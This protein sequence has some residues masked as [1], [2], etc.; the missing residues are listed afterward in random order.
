MMA[1]NGV[2]RRLW[3]VAVVL[4][5]VAS[6]LAVGAAPVSGVAGE[7][8]NEPVYS[9]C[10]GPALES[11]G[12]VDVVG[13]FAEDA[14]NCLA[15]FEVTRGRTETTYDPGAPVLRWQMALFLARAAGPAGIA[16][17]ANPEVG[18]TDTVGLFEEGRTAIAQMAQ[19]RVMRGR[20]STSFRP[21]EPVSRAE[22]AEMLD[23]FLVEAEKASGLGLGAL[24]GGGVSLSDVSADD[25][26]FSDIGSVTRGQYAAVR[27]MFEAGVARGAADG[28]FNPG[29]LVTRAQMAVFITRM[30]AH[31]AARPAGLTIQA[32]ESEAV[33]GDSVE[34]AVS[35]RDND[36][37]P[38]P[39]ALVDVFSAVDPG[40]AFGEDGR[41]D[42]DVVSVVGGGGV[43][44]ISLA[45]LSTD[46]SGDLELSADGLAGSTTVW[47]W[48]GDE[49]DRYD[50]GETEA[51]S[52]RI[53]VVKPGV[54]LRV[55]DD[56]PEGATSLEFGGRVVFTLQVVDEDGEAAAVE[57][58][59]VRVSVSETRV[60]A[61]SDPA[62]EST[63][64]STSVYE[65]D[66]SGSI[67][68]SFRQTDPRPGSGDTGDSA[69]LDLDVIPLG[70]PALELEDETNLKK[71]G[72]ESGGGAEDA[73]A[74]WLDSEPTPTALMLS[75]DVAYQEASKAGSGAAHVVEATL[76]DQFGNPIRGQRIHFTSD[77][78]LGVGEEAEDASLAAVRTAVSDFSTTAS[79]RGWRDFRNGVLD[80]LIGKSRIV[81][82]TNARG[83]A[84]LSYN[85]RADTAVI[86]TILARLVRGQDDAVLPD[87]AG[88]RS[89]ATN[90]AG[91]ED[92]LSERLAV[93]WAKELGDGDS[94]A[95]RILV[96]DTENN[97]I[98]FGG[99]DGRVKMVAYDPNDH[100]NALDGPALLADFEE[101]LDA[102]AAHISVSDYD[103]NSRGVNFFTLAP[104]WRQVDMTPIAV[105]NTVQTDSTTH[106]GVGAYASDGDTTVIGA[107][108]ENDYA[109]AVYVYD[110]PG[111]TPVKLTAPTPQPTTW[112]LEDLSPE[113]RGKWYYKPWHLNHPEAG[114]WFGYDV[115]IRG[116]TI[117]VGEPGRTSTR[118]IAHGS[119]TDPRNGNATDGAAYVY[120]KDSNGAWNLDATLTA[121]GFAN[122]GGAPHNHHGFEFGRSVGV[123]GNEQVIAV[124]APRYINNTRVGGVY[125]F[126]RP[127]SAADGNW[128][129]DNGAGASRL[130]PAQS[131]LSANSNSW[132]WYFTYDRELDISE[133]G[134][135][136][137]ASANFFNAM[138]DG[139]RH[140]WTG[141]AYVFTKPAA[142]W[143]RAV[144]TPDA[145]LQSPNPLTAERVGRSVAVSADG[146]TVV[147]SANFRPTMLR[148]GSV[149]V[150]ERP[151]APIGADDNWADAPAPTAVLRPPD[152][153][154]APDTCEP[155]GPV[156]GCNLGEIFGIWVDIT[157]D[158]NKILAS[159]THRTEG[160]RRGS[161]HLFT[162]PGGG[163]STVTDDNQP[164]SVEHLGAA[165]RSGLGWR[166]VFDQANGAVYAYATDPDREGA[167]S[168]VGAQGTGAR[169]Y[170]IPP[171]E[172]E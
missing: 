61:G 145:K 66:A 28:L 7:A 95:G 18:F 44:E 12:L 4:G 124:G 162:K 88:F 9:A 35:V 142:G 117:V 34:L 67:E 130:A 139:V 109:G 118:Q 96:A 170:R 37:A 57:D 107:H 43:C 140:E 133:D 105:A 122:E 36:L 19:L 147:V 51:S 22:M 128:N 157:D 125:V 3:S 153:P 81:R 120:T 166:N 42:A 155:A 38:M 72:R 13:S 25:E 33:V 5:L 27:R 87:R 75:Q 115:D 11:Q 137:V 16:L 85:R 150:F 144:V 146:G 58:V 74:V 10:V 21:N 161:V 98:V 84:T 116:G 158:G 90:E 97:R 113:D 151:A 154:D 49:G 56:M 134:S 59:S 79:T 110:G 2:R 78:P 40:E 77:D 131:D 52:I 41:C 8:D 50:A 39:D 63:Q 71:A 73:A 138:L 132:S 53:A 23:S 101:D 135:T 76:T 129:D 141:A 168:S 15:H 47:A 159:R 20:S 30:L 127:A 112:N 45:D 164:A 100:F 167:A 156:L 82:T 93:Y 171:S 165:A 102:D 148:R 163:W 80:N 92:L 160:E 169:M 136:V 29:G 104:E 103:D 99:A 126:E 152:H 6:L 48:T 60:D 32:A 70:S 64:M 26:V 83:V 111:A 69:R 149:L 24:G 17:P 14:V 91:E 119:A 65:T 114:G 1:C 143:T 123:S 121:G 108:T 172:T 31:T 46:P 68:L 86:E 55:T 62:E 89:R 54:K 106:I 94:A